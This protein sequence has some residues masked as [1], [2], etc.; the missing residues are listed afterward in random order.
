MFRDSVPNL[1]SE[2]VPEDFLSLNEFL[3]GMPETTPIVDVK[4]YHR[5]TLSY[6]SGTTGYWQGAE[7]GY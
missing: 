1:T 5:A 3:E 2:S 7:R 6:T 4:P